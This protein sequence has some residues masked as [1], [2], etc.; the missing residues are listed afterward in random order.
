MELGLPYV[1]LEQ[2]TPDDSILAKIPRGLARRNT[3]LPLFVDDDMLLVA[4][5]DE[6]THDLED[7]LRLRVG[8]PMRRLIASPLSINQGIAKFYAGLEADEESVADAGTVAKKKKKAERKAEVVVP[9]SSEAKAAEYKTR[10]IG[11]ILV[12]WS[13]VVPVVIDL[14]VLP[15]SLKV[16]QIM[17]LSLTLI[18]SPILLFL[19]WNSYFR[20]K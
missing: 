14:F 20:R 3:I 7:E 11:T 2:L 4:C 18:A 1:D 17:D 19:V 12:C 16:F 13:L 15:K 10:Q 9:G 8:V 5:V 6:P